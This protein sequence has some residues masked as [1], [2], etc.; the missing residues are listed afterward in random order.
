MKSDF[1]LKTATLESLGP[2][3]QIKRNSAQAIE[4]DTE[5]EAGPDDPQWL[6]S[7]K[8]IRVPHGRT[9]CSYKRISIFQKHLFFFSLLICELMALRIS[10][11]QAWVQ[12]G[13]FISQEFALTY[14]LSGAF[15][16]SLSLKYS[17]HPA[18][19]PVL[20]PGDP[21]LL[22]TEQMRSLSTHLKYQALGGIDPELIIRRSAGVFFPSIF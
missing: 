5:W 7:S 4:K 9:R 15:L 16:G 10:I 14:F 19:R 18:T 21:T 3:A 11:N 6:L 12:H 8:M 17:G 22:C 13:Y 2:A 20:G 1:T